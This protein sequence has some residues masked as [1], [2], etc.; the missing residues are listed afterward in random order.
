V[1][2]PIVWLKGVIRTPP[3]SVR[4]RREAGHLLWMLQDGASLGLP[5]SRPMPSIGRGCHE[6]RIEDSDHSWRIVYCIEFTAIVI[7]DV[8]AK[9]SQDTP[10]H[11]I[12][13]CRRRLARFRGGSGS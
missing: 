10:T 1:S 8:F 11:V 7:L 4:A 2:K 6:L 9:S 13:T 12:D 3:F 5:A